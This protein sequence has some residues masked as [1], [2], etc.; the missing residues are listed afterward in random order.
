M[1]S[2]PPSAF[3]AGRIRETQRDM[4]VSNPT[5][6]SRNDSGKFFN[7]SSKSWSLS[8]FREIDLVSGSFAKRQ[9]NQTQIIPI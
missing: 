2:I 8:L 1:A 9:L 6:G 7:T 5:K 4:K 3:S